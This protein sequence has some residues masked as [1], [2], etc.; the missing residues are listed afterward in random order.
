[1]TRREW[2]TLGEAEI[3]RRVRERIAAFGAS[4]AII[5]YYLCDE[6]EIEEFE[7]QGLVVA[8]VRGHAPGKL[9]YINLFPEH[10]KRLDG[11]R[12]HSGYS[13]ADY[14]TVFIEE[15]RVMA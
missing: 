5:G 13:Y 4:D 1:M 3:D 10:H 2:V 11:V 6:P 8:A 7:T 9:A 12:D 15:V 14:L